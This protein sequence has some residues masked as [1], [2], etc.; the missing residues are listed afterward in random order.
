MKKVLNILKIFNVI[1]LTLFIIV[2]FIQSQIRVKII[3][4]V[5]NNEDASTIILFIHILQSLSSTILFIKLLL[6][7][8]RIKALLKI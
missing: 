3:L 7:N 6:N 2:T 5:K 1:I 8:E 4:S